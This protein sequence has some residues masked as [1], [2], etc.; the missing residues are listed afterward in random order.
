[1]P[2]RSTYGMPFHAAGGFVTAIVTESTPAMQAALRA[3]SPPMPSGRN[4]EQCPVLGRGALQRFAQVVVCQRAGG[5]DDQRH[6]RTQQRGPEGTH[7]LVRGCFDHDLRLRGQQRVESNYEGH[8][9][10]RGQRFPARCIAAPD[11][12]DDFRRSQIAGPDVLE[13]QARDRPPADDAY[14][15]GRSSCADSATSDPRS[16]AQPHHP[17]PS[18]DPFGEERRSNLPAFLTAGWHAK[19]DGVVRHL[20]KLQRSF[21]CNS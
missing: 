6:A 7:R 5:Q 15:H 11:D 14:P 21:P 13:T 12:R 3:S 16:P 20:C 4:V 2:S 19:R 1:M 10:L 18:A 8:T 17:R 9:E